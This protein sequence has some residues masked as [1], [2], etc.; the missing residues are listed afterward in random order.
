MGPMMIPGPPPPGA[1]AANAQPPQPQ[2]PPGM[3]QPQYMINVT[4]PPPGFAMPPPPGYGFPPGQPPQQQPQQPAPAD[5]KPKW[6]EDLELRL[7]ED[8]KRNTSY[9]HPDG[10]FRADSMGPLAALP[11]PTQ[12]PNNPATLPSD[13][14]AYRIKGIQ[15]TSMGRSD[16]GSEDDML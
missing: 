1:P 12:D 9:W 15:L 14:Y 11:G 2:R 13:Y 6:A 5:K 7:K 3:P 16:C 8:W 10:T 4:G